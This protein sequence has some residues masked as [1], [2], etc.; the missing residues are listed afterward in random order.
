MRCCY[1]VV[2]HHALSCRR[3]ALRELLVAEIALASRRHTV[4][5]VPLQLNCTPR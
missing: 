2:T 1:S 3:L 5:R 4:L